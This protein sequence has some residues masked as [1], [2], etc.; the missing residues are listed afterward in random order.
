MLEV[1]RVVA[2][3][4]LVG[5]LEQTHFDV[6]LPDVV[7]LGVERDV[8]DSLGGMDIKHLTRRLYG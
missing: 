6:E 2:L 7:A 5:L 8:L 4:D 3:A 1:L